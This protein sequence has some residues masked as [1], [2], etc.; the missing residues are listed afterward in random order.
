[1]V[2]ELL[3]ISR[4]I[5]HDNA[6]A[7]LDRWYATPLKKYYAGR[8]HSRK[9]NVM[10]WHLSVCM[11]R[12]HTR[13]DSPGGSIRRGQRTFRPDNKEDRHTC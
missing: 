3:A 2:L 7:A 4:G 10:V 1:M 11:S 9:R 8:V 13:R 6:Y 5:V 12:R